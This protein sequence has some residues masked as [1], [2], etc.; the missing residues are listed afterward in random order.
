M[1]AEHSIHR[2]PAPAPPVTDWRKNNNQALTY[3]IV[4][5]ENHDLIRFVNVVKNPHKS[6]VWRLSFRLFVIVFIIWSN[7]I[8]K[9]PIHKLSFTISNCHWLGYME[10]GKSHWFSH[11]VLRLTISNTKVTKQHFHMAIYLSQEETSKCNSDWI[12]TSMT[13]PKNSHKH[14]IVWFCFGLFCF[15]RADQ[16]RNYHN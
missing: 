4:S 3:W 14:F 9:R 16:N 8:T 1:G 12:L 2:A 11:F 13:K 10:A 6:V 15:S 5:I 7:S